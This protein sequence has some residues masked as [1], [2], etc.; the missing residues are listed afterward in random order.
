FCKIIK[1]EYQDFD[2][3]NS[4]KILLNDSNYQLTWI[5]YNK[6]KNIKKIGSGGIATVYSASWRTTTTSFAKSIQSAP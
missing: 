4:I 6:F 1:E 3:D 2:I 5:S